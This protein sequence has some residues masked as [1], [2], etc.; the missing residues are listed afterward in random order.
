[1]TNNVL[2][3]TLAILSP[4]ILA[5]FVFSFQIEARLTKIETDISWM[6]GEKEGCQQNSEDLTR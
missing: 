2:F 3:K 6:R 4:F 1:M 5:I